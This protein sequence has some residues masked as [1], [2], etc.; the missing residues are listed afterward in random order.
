MTRHLTLLTLAACLAVLGE[1]RA[2]IVYFPG[3]DIDI[4]NTY[5]G[6]SVDLETGSW[7]TA[8]NGLSGGGPEEKYCAA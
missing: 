1:A 3:Q 2:A 7:T 6:V 4:P 8:L 5:A